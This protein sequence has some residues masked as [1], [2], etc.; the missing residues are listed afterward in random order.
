MT[1]LTVP[2]RA[3][4]AAVLAEAPTP[5]PV[6]GVNVIRIKPGR[7]EEFMALQ[8]AHLERIRGTVPGVVGSR[9]LV[10]PERDAVVLV[11][12]F[13]T[14]EHAQAFRR[15]PRFVEHLERAGGLVESTE[16]MPVE[17]AYEVGVI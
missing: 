12:A 6:L 4:V 8:M 1:T 2:D 15:D 17:L 5:R 11:S 10:S 9:M 14:A 16:A 3:T 13:D 7:F